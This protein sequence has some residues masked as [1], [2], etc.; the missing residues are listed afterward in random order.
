M[1]DNKYELASEFEKIVKEQRE[2]LAVKLEHIFR[3][4]INLHVSELLELLD[5][6]IVQI[7][8]DVNVEQ[9]LYVYYSWLFRDLENKTIVNFVVEFNKLYHS[10]K[11]INA[12]KVIHD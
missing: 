3:S 1:N 6:D 7:K 5:N 11:K 2:L 8:V 10:G 4:S 12:I 9:F